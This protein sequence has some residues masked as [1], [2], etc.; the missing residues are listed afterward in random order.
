VGRLSVYT[1]ALASLAAEGRTLIRSRQLGELLD[2]HPEQIRKDFSYIGHLGRRGNGYDVGLLEAELRRVLV[3]DKTWRM[4]LIG[5]D[6]LGLDNWAAELVAWGFSIEAAFER[7]VD[8]GKTSLLA[9]P[10]Y[11]LQALPAFL[12]EH[13]VDV[14][15]LAVPPVEAQGVADVLVHGGVKAILNYAPMVIHVPEHILVRSIDP[16]AGLL[17]M[18]FCL[19]RAGKDARLSG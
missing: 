14:A 1:R 19:H 16:I 17:E 13:A 11:A 5:A 3:A 12:S 18:A 4:V 9:V 2:I 6:N 15:I 10:C 8:A 7:E